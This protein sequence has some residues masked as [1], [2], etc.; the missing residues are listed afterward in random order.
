MEKETLKEKN[1]WTS[2]IRK[3]T[4]A[5]KGQKQKK[6]LLRKSKET[7][8]CERKFNCRQRVQ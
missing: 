2:M 5:R 3:N 6:L 8:D 1:E 7:K 4:L